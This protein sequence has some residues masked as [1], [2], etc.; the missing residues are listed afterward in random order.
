MRFTVPSMVTRR[1]FLA[2][3]L[4]A[5]LARAVEAQVAPAGQMLLSIHQNTSRAA[6]FRGSLEE[7]EPAIAYNA[8][9]GAVNTLTKD[10]AVKL[11]PYGIRVNAIAPG[12]F[13]TD[14]M[15]Y[16]KGDPVRLATFFEQ[17]PLRRPGGEDDVKGAVVFLA[18]DA[19][20]Y[21]TGHNLVLDGG[22]LVRA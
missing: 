4:A 2:A 3:S 14:M 5:P 16:V 21:V 20:A 19:G 22:W 6:G 9:K 1:T 8:A 7:K 10:M 15:E 13:D 18:S 11:A 17:I 12:A